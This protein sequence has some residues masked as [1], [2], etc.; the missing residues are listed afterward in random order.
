MSMI[1]PYKAKEAIDHLSKGVQLNEVADY[2]LN[3]MSQI[4]QTTD[5]A[6]KGVRA[7]KAGPLALDIST[8]HGSVICNVEHV[9]MGSDLAARLTFVATGK[10]V[11]GNTTGRNILTV[12]V[13]ADWFV[14]RIDE[15]PL[16]QSGR[17]G[18]AARSDDVIID[19]SVLVFIALQG[20]LT[21]I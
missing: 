7:T 8:P 5:Y 17:F 3:G 20:S 15:T 9:R 21:E 13:T 4:L 12:V 18:S 6:S 2:F 10:D 16:P 19:V 14:E 1:D 11:A